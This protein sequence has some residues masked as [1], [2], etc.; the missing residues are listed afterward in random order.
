VQPCLDLP[1][2]TRAMR[3]LRAN[4]NRFELFRPARR[5]GAAGPAW[6]F[7]DETRVK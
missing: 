5:K 7:G 1:V 6:I 2:Y 4:L 3:R